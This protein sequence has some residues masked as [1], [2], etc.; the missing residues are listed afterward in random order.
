MNVDNKGREQIEG[1]NLADY[2]G[3]DNDPTGAVQALQ[4]DPRDSADEA[5]IVLVKTSLPD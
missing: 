2:S 5:P 4:H 1:G 3:V